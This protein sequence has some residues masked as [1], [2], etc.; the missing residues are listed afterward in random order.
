[1]N[2]VEKIS[3]IIMGILGI[4]IIVDVFLEQFFGI[5]TKQNSLTLIYCISFVLLTTQ[6]KSILKNKLIMIPFYIMILQTSYS[7]ITKY[8]L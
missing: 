4:V 3:P 2:K 1:M 6:F 8:V 7:L 5:G